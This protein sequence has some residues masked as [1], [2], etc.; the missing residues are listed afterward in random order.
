MT[1]GPR[2]LP[3]DPGRIERR[4]LR[5]PTRLTSGGARREYA[6]RSPFQGRSVHERVISLVHGSRIDGSLQRRTLGTGRGQ[7]FSINEPIGSAPVRA[8]LTASS[9]LRDGPT[10]RVSF[11]RFSGKGG[12]RYRGELRNATRTTLKLETTGRRNRDSS[13]DAER[14]VDLLH[15]RDTPRGRYLRAGLR[16]LEPRPLDRFV[17]RTAMSSSALT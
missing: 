17:F 5:L 3:R 7:R 12:V 9:L 8:G 4:T 15:R 16:D 14:T 6:R 1:D 11:P 2:Q 10:C 13:G